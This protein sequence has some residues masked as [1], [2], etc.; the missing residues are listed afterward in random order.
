MTELTLTPEAVN[1]ARSLLAKRPEMPGLRISVER[2]GCA[3]YRWRIGYAETTGPEDQRIECG[4]VALFV[5]SAD[6]PLVRGTTVDYVRQG[7]NRMFRFENPRAREVCGCG[8][9][10]TV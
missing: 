2:S 10:F 5:A 6:L 7:L 4:G 9:S 8:E 1:Q 3:G